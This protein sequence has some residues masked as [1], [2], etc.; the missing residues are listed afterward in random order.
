MLTERRLPRLLRFFVRDRRLH[1]VQRLF[2][3]LLFFFKRRGAFFCLPQLRL[4]PRPLGVDRLLLSQSGDFPFPTFHFRAAAVRLLRR[5]FGRFRPC[6]LSLK[7]F[8]LRPLFFFRR[9]K[10]RFFPPPAFVKRADKPYRLD[11]FGKLG[12]LRADRFSLRDQGR[13]LFPQR[14]ALL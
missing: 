2:A 6:P 14:V 9:H 1:C 13:L 3:R 12:A 10:R 5:G 7:R 8:R 11:L 4:L